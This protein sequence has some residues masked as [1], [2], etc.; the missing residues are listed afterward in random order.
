MFCAKEQMLNV[1]LAYILLIIWD[2]IV[3]SVPY[4]QLT[5]H[6]LIRAL[7]LLKSFLICII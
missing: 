1:H 6:S 2:F 3:H 5:L 4:V 7:N